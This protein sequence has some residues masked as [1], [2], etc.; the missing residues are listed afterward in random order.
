M[1]YLLF[2]AKHVQDQVYQDN[3]VL[4]KCSVFILDI[5]LATGVGFGRLD[6]A[7]PFAMASVSALFRVIFMA[8]ASASSHSPA[9]HG[10]DTEQHDFTGPWVTHT[11]LD[12][13]MYE[14]MTLKEK[15]RKRNKY[16][17]EYLVRSLTKI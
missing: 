16:L 15:I 5:F 13:R 14:R 4:C 12:I 17:E 3:L 10:R 11:L 8:S 6:F 1:T 2:L 7:L 9:F